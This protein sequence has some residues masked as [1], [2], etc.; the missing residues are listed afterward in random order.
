MN[1]P[2]LLQLTLE[3]F[4][5][6]RDTYRLLPLN[7]KVLI[8]SSDLTFN[9]FPESKRVWRLAGLLQ[10][11]YG[12]LDWAEENYRENIKNDPSDAASVKRIISLYKHQGKMAECVR[13]LNKLGCPFENYP[14][15]STSFY[16]RFSSEVFHKF[17]CFLHGKIVLKFCWTTQKQ[18]LETYQCDAESWFELAEIYLGE[19]E[20]EKAAFCFEELIVI[21]PT[22]SI[23]HQVRFLGSLIE[24][25]LG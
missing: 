5:Q 9:Y 24:L 21:N 10:E 13:E 17:G 6:P 15:F 16:S 12:E 7:S 3:N 2:S 4:P 20:Y 22:N 8:H 18:Y 23:V 25:R 14:K 19:H 11:S 1:R